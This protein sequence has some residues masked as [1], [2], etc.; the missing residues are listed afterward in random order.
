MSDAGPA[1]APAS[2]ALPPL[3][4]YQATVARA[5]VRRVLG[6]E[7]GSISVEIARPG[8]KNELQA[9]VG[10]IT[11]PHHAPPGGTAVQGGRP[12]DQARQGWNGYYLIG[13]RCFAL[14]MGL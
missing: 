2:T 13:D 9:E 10:H 1:T 7:G 3:R 12:R 14:P 5:I 11:L 8:G 6:P 4:P